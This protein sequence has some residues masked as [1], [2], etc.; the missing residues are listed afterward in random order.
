MTKY[1]KFILLALT[2]LWGCKESKISAPAKPLDVNDL[3]SLVL[4]AINGDRKANDSLSGL[5]ETELIENAAYN[6]LTV[7]SFSVDTLKFFYVLLEYPNPIFNRLA[8][9]DD[10]TNCYLIDKSLNGK[11]SVDV[12]EVQDLKFLKVVE[13]FLVKDT[14]EVIRLSFY[15]NIA[16]TIKLVYRNFAELKTPKQTFIQTITSMDGDTIKTKLTVPKKVKNISEEDFF[17]YDGIENYYKSSNSLFDSLVIK[18]INDFEIETQK[19]NI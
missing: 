6:S 4:K 13:S 12:L 16:Q 3:S 15:K 1:F 17:F 8:F 14:L 19:P 10:K 7:D 11:I 18:E 2:L 5:I 9:Y